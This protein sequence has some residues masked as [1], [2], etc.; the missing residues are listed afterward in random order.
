M[1]NLGIAI[2][3]VGVAVSAAYG[4]RLSPPMRAQM[5]LRG[6]AHVRAATTGE[7]QGAYCAALVELLPDHDAAVRAL[8]EADGCEL[9]AEGA[10]DEAS[11]AS[12]PD[13][14]AIC[15]A[16]A[17]TGQTFEQITEEARG[18]VATHRDRDASALGA[19]LVEARDAWLAAMDA[20]VEPAARA[21]VLAPIP[22]AERLSAWIEDSG[23]FF[24]L[25][26]L[27]VVLGAVLGRTAS[28]RDAEAPA[29]AKSERAPARDF[30][31]LLDE[32]RA[33]VAKLAEE[34]A[35]KEKP[36][37]A[38]Y[39]AL[40]GKI[41]ELVV[42]KVEPI[43][44]SAPRVQSKHGIAIFADV[45]SPFSSGERYLNRAWSALV[46][47]HWP[48]AASSLERS[49]ADLAEA[50]RA[51]PTGADAEGAAPPSTATDRP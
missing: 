48:E 47:R 8:A 41:H 2:L 44:D 23:I 19:E 43:V 50:R 5:V 28:K 20:E 32:L 51:L 14:T 39:E 11:D 35:A 21:A 46:D 38:D 3:C 17:S 24:G 12:G 18:E 22:P 1:K 40:K 13:V 34:A 33:A 49:A 27:L 4:A 10:A 42:E 29:D 30:G 16:R 7:T 31:E 25:G 37:T 15:V 26:L 45:F 9:P 36:S 6:E